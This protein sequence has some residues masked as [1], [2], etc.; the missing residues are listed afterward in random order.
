MYSGRFCWNS[1]YPPRFTDAL[2]EV[3]GRC[4]T[5]HN[6]HETYLIYRNDCD[7]I[8]AF[9]GFPF[10]FVFTYA[11]ITKYTSSRG[12]IMNFGILREILWNGLVTSTSHGKVPSKAPHSTELSQTS[13]KILSCIITVNRIES[14][15]TLPQAYHNFEI[16]LITQAAWWLWV[17]KCRCFCFCFLFSS[18]LNFSLVRG[19]LVTRLN[20]LNFLNFSHALFNGGFNCLSS[21]FS[22]E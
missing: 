9:I 1:L 6:T 16:N 21:L 5:H 4:L 2:F 19:T 3:T 10:A 13:L 8:T 7:L 17:I 22:I 12:I 20:F 14:N 15:V 11:L 18:T